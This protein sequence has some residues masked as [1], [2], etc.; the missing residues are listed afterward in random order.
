MSQRI[1]PPTS[2]CSSN[3]NN[4]NNNSN[5]SHVDNSWSPL[6]ELLRT[7]K[8]SDVTLICEDRAYLLHKA[9][10]CTQSPVLETAL[11]GNFQEAITNTYTIGGF[12]LPIVQAMIDFMYL[13]DYSLDVD[14]T[15]A[16]KGSEELLSVDYE[17]VLAH[18]QVNSIGDYF[19]ITKLQDHA[20]MHIR[21]IFEGPFSF[22]AGPYAQIALQAWKSTG[23]DELHEMIAQLGAANI[24]LLTELSEFPSLDMMSGFLA[25][26]LRYCSGTVGDSFRVLNSPRRRMASPESQLSVPRHNLV[27]LGE[28]VKKVIAHDGCMACGRAFGCTVEQMEID[29]E[30]EYTVQC[31]GCGA[32]L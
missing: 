18:M 1:S 3:N 4:S 12:D 14:A 10:I 15:M 17:R 21:S 8:Y 32:T 20:N 11:T 7:G 9:I 30:T 19:G 16:K 27:S 23:D 31:S 5:M 26:V 13:N 6:P 29:N 22:A 2:S 24:E 25:K 28:A